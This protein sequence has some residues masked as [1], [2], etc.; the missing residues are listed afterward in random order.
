MMKGITTRLS[1]EMACFLLLL[2]PP[3]GARLV[4]LTA[5]Q[6]AWQ[7]LEMGALVQY[8]IGLFGELSNNYACANGVLPPEAFAPATPVDTDAW[9]GAARSFGAKYALLTVQAGCGFLLYP[10]N[11][12]V[13]NG[14]RYPYTTRAAPSPT[15]EA[16]D[17]VKRFVD[18]CR[19]A[20]IRPGLYYQVANNVFCNVTAG[21]VNGGEGAVGPCGNQ[22]QYEELAVAQLRELWGSAGYG[23]LSELWFDGG[24]N[25]GKDPTPASLAARISALIAQLQPAA[26]AFQA[27]Y[28]ASVGGSRSLVRWAGTESGITAVDTWSTARDAVDYGAGEAD[29]GLGAVMW[30]PV[31][32]G[33]LHP[34]S[35]L[36]LVKSS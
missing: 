8:N 12:S 21:K 2:L 18:S 1:A 31:E 28:V 22:T 13:R 35:S 17:I 27:P 25:S 24:V 36:S 29:S 26:V 33:E 30:A 16:P 19:A 15:S 7:D 3:C 11:T 20:G 9:A 23:A 6:L 34:A 5:E 14:T 10:T 4:R 32:C